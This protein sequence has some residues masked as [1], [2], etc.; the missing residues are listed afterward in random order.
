MRGEGKEDEPAPAIPV[1]RGLGVGFQYPVNH[2]GG[3]GCQNEQRVAGAAVVGKVLDGIPQRHQYVKVGE[4]TAD[5]PPQQGAATD[6]P[7]QHGLA[8]SSPQTY[9]R[10][11]VHFLDVSTDQSFRV[12]YNRSP[13]ILKG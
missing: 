9:L 2:Q 13:A 4:Q 12:E 6:L 3:E 1:K 10:H 5:S 8:D 11:G 7:P